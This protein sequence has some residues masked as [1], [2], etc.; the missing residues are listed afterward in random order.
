MYLYLVKMTTHANNLN[1]HDC[2]VVHKTNLTCCNNIHFCR[3]KK[4]RQIMQVLI[5]C[6]KKK[7]ISFALLRHSRKKNEQKFSK[8]SKKQQRTNSKNVHF[9]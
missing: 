3:P 2:V 5:K 4:K 9:K 1:A 7:K 6:I 8:A